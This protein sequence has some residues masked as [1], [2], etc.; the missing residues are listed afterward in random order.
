MAF[1][2]SDKTLEGVL[3]DSQQRLTLVERRIAQIA[4]ISAIPDAT[5]VAEG[6]G[7]DVTGNGSTATPYKIATG[8]TTAERN[9]RYGAVPTTDPARVALANQRPVWFNTDLGWEEGYYAVTGLSGLTARGLVAGVTSGWYPTGPGGPRIYLV[10]GVQQPLVTGNT[11]T[12]WNAP[13][14]GR[15]WQ[16]GGTAWF[17]YTPAS[18]S[19]ACVKAGRYR[20]TFMMT[21]Q[22]GSGSGLL[23]LIKNNSGTDPNVVAQATPTLGSWE[24][25]FTMTQP[26]LLMLAGDNLRMYAASVGGATF[27]PA[28][29]GN[30]ERLGTWA[31]EYLGPALVNDSA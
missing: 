23:Y 16:R 29:D 28:A 22:A 31:M 10:A 8:G 19:I 6:F 20:C 4:R 15:S 14:N 24:T 17:T 2:P 21:I 7:V 18:G 11:Y 3:T 30:K 1:P 9:T 27:A 13:G 25:P 5:V 12:G 26:D